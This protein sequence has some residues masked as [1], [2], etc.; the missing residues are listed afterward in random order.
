MV[1]RKV[2]LSREDYSASV[3][4][5]V[6]NLIEDQEFTDVTLVCEDNQ[7]IKAHKVILSA[8]SDFFQTVLTVN[9]HQHPLIYLKGISKKRLKQ[10]IEFIYIGETNVEE[11]DVD[12]FLELGKDLKIA[13]L[14]DDLEKVEEVQEP[15]HARL[16][17]ADLDLKSESENDTF[18]EE[19]ANIFV[20][21]EATIGSMTTDKSVETIDE[22]VSSPSF[23]KNKKTEGPEKKKI[24]ELFT[25]YTKN[26]TNTGADS[27]D[28]KFS[29]SKCEFTTMHQISFK[30]HILSKHEG[31]RYQ[32]PQCE[33]SYSASGPLWR[34]KKTVHEGFIH[35]C[36]ICE[37]EFPEPSAAYR[38][39]KNAHSLSN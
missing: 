19:T 28:K 16:E 5:S 32:C 6:N 18:V 24:K 38:H 4:K 39:K 21:S 12:S 2:N 29:C 33:K 3:T 14:V 34:H 30:Q 10:V 8:S 35:R 22:T 15:T 7:Q 31:F 27:M 37:K 11:I 26:E 20:E 17:S 13:G 23:I 25:L 9:R 1:S 36:E